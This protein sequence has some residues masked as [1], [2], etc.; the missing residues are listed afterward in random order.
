MI[1]PPS[2]VVKTL[3][4]VK[5]KIVASAFEPTFVPF[6]EEPNASAASSIRI[7]PASSICFLISKILHGNPP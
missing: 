2:P 5:L 7:S 4:P 6:T 3:F 1:A